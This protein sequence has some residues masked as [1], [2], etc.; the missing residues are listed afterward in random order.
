M[1]S[2]CDKIVSTEAPLRD[3]SPLNATCRP[4]MGDGPSRPLGLPRIGVAV[5]RAVEASHVR[6]DRAIALALAAD[7]ET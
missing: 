4:A 5:A 2:G 3:A 6:I 1:E 7:P